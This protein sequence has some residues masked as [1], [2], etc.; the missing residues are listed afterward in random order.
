MRKKAKERQPSLGPI[1]YFRGEQGDRWWL[2]ALF[3]F[4]GDADPNDL[5]VDGV[6]LAIPPRH[7]LAWHGRHVWRFDFAVPRGPTDSAVDYGFEYTEHRWSIAIPARNGTPRMAFTARNG[8]DASAPRDTAWRA[9]AAQH[10]LTPFHILLHGGDQIRADSVWRDCPSL[11]AWSHAAKK[12]RATTAFSASMAEESMS[13]YIDR[14]TTAW[15]QPEVAAVLARVPSVMMWDGHD[16]F[17]GWRGPDKGKRSLAAPPVIPPVVRGVAMVARRVFAAFQLAGTPE[18]PPECVWADKHG[19]FTQGFRLGDI[20]I[21]APD[22]RSDRTPTRVLSE[23]TWGALPAW[24]ERFQGCRHLLLLS[25]IPLLFADFDQVRGVVRCLPGVRS[26]RNKQRNP[27]RNR[28]H[29]EE[30]QLLLE[31]LA[32]FSLRSDC[33]ITVLSGAMHFGARTMLHGGGVEMWQL[34]SSQAAHPPPGRLLRLA[35]EQ[36]TAREDAPLPGWSLTTPPFSETGHRL[37]HAST[38]MM[39]HVDHK[40]QLHAQW[41][42]GE[43]A[44]GQP[45][46]YL[47]VI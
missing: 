35:L 29:R 42:A 23:R 11:D 45:D 8:I 13:Y 28:A 20:G 46:R 1:L 43:H 47:Q 26:L 19:G 9:L 25:S 31:F 18:S 14:Y 15:S 39:L 7:V 12:T 30:W 36:F 34:V 2:S 32:S 16:I 24:L 41:C 17:A 33:R 21:L 22:L 3:V 5:R 4:E 10:V 44:E 37:I 6:G 27:W 40:N 38:W